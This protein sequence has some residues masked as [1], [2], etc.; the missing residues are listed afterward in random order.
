MPA[1]FNAGVREEDLWPR[2]MSALSRLVRADALAVIV[3]LPR[4]RVIV[5]AAHGVALTPEWLHRDAAAI[6]ARA[7]AQRTA[8][9]AVV[10]PIALTDGRAATSIIA[11]PVPTGGEAASVLVGLRA[12]GSFTPQDAGPLGRAAELVAVEMRAASLVQE[13]ERRTNEATAQLRQAEH[14]RRLAL[15]LYEL[16]RLRGDPDTEL[17]RALTVCTE[18][19]GND[20]VAILIRRGGRVRV[21]ASRPF[22]PPANDLPSHDAVERARDGTAV[23]ARFDPGDAPAWAPDAREAIAAPIDAA[24]GTVL[25]VARATRSFQPGETDVMPLVSAEFGPILARTPG[26]PVEGSSRWEGAAVATTVLLL[27]QAAILAGA[28]AYGVGTVPG[29]VL[30]GPLAGVA[31][32]TAR[33]G[34]TALLF[35]LLLSALAFAERTSAPL[36]YGARGDLAFWLET[37]GAIVALA[38]VVAAALALRVRAWR[39][40]SP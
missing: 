6:V 30:A 5:F 11:T 23:L 3:T 36:L 26:P 34:R 22:R 35:A 21:R 2:R 20:S 31:G 24:G 39:R 9:G 38:G 27:A 37:G 17:E 14:D 29:L 16:A 28:V 33:G 19:L 18:V 25:V 15:A 10:A 1:C 4:D 13:L 7:L 8:T 12:Q 32:G 40:E